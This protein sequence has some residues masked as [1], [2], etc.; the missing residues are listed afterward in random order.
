[1]NLS[2]ISGCKN[3]QPYPGKTYMLTQISY[4]VGNDEQSYLTKRLLK[5]FGASRRERAE[6][7]V[8]IFFSMFLNSIT[9]RRL[10]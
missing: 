7:Q 10:D 1:M 8:I 9:L 2:T 3:Q 6:E 5:K 4:S